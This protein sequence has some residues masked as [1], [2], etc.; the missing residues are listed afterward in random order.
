M[1]IGEI[2]RKRHEKRLEL[3]GG[4][5]VFDARYRILIASDIDR[6]IPAELPQTALFEGACQAF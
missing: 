6:Q 5:L 3:R 2:A 1:L 4:E